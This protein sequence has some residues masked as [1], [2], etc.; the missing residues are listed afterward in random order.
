VAFV[1][2]L[3]DTAAGRRPGSLTAHVDADFG[4]QLRS[5]P[6][7]ATLA[8]PP[9]C[10]ITLEAGAGYGAVAVPPPSD[11]DPP[12]VAARQEA[13]IARLQASTEV[14]ATCPM[15]ADEGEEKRVETTVIFAISIE[16]GRDGRWR[17]LAWR[18]IHGERTH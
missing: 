16:R 2:L 15:A 12:D 6:L 1:Q 3:V 17:A 7:D 10:A 11:R 4:R 13:L 5:A 14:T 8:V 9:G 18:R